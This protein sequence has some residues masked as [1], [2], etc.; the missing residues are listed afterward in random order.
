[1]QDYPHQVYPLIKQLSTQRLKIES[2][3]LD[4]VYVD[5]SETLEREEDKEL[6]LI[7]FVHG[8]MGSHRDLREYRNR[9]SLAIRNKYVN[10]R[11]VDEAFLFSSSNE[12]NSMEDLEIMGQNLANE[13]L[14]HI[15]GHQLYFAKIS[16]ICHS[17]GGLIAKA[18][19]NALQFA[20]LL[21]RVQNLI[22]FG[23]PHLSLAMHDHQMIN[24]AMGVY[25][26]FAKT[27]FV[28]Q[29][30]MKDGETLDDCLIFKLNQSNKFKNIIAFASKQ[31]LYVPY[32]SAI[33]QS[34]Q[35]SNGYM[36][37]SVDFP[38][39]PYDLLGRVA[40]LSFLTSKEFMDMSILEI[41][42]GLSPVPENVLATHT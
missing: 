30:Y 4:N 21:P 13:I 17:L 24:A 27:K 18:A 3:F 6:H 36:G 9:I 8:L 5:D 28:D 10:S 32:E 19:V 41:E 16:F 25:S 40:H 39:L 20:E 1:V 33:F 31:D 22:T 37:Y 7:C 29:M 38:N 26:I 2:M 42:E 34:C 14:N 23:T 12:Q 15:H 35:E 11:V